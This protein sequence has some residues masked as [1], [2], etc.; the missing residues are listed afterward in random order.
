MTKAFKFTLKLNLIGV[1][2]RNIEKMTKASN[3]KTGTN[4]K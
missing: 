2:A 1:N 3:T 4:T